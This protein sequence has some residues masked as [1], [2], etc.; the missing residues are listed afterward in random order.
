MTFE[1]QFDLKCCLNWGHGAVFTVTSE[2]SFIIPILSIPQ[3]FNIYG[4]SNIPRSMTFL[5]QQVYE[6]PDFN[7]CKA[8]PLE[9]SPPGATFGL[10]EILTSNIFR[11]LKTPLFE[12]WPALK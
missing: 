8:E 10:Y 7:L 3:I 9:Q 6:N 5:Q 11:G 1:L 12:I 2:I 4:K